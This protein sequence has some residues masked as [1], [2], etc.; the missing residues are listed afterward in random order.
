VTIIVLL[1]SRVWQKGRMRWYDCKR[2]AGGG[3][4]QTKN[5][6]AMEN[7]DLYWDIKSSALTFLSFTNF[8]KLFMFFLVP[9]C[10]FFGGIRVAVHAPADSGTISQLISDAFLGQKPPIS[11]ISVTSDQ[12]RHF[13]LADKVAR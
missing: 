9:T 13:P 3:H 5:L 10:N 11:R 1:G 7:G 4:K 8:V 2:P 12:H 6:T